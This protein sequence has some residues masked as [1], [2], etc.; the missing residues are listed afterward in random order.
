MVFIPT[1][2]LSLPSDSEVDFSDVCTS[3]ATVV[4]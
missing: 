1:F 4:I 3:R 2:P